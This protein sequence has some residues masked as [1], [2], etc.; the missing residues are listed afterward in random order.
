M[1]CRGRVADAFE[2]K[3]SGADVPEDQQNWLEEALFVANEIAPK[4]L[5]LL[6]KSFSDA[7]E[8]D[9]AEDMQHSLRSVVVLIARLANHPG[10][11]KGMDAIAK[12]LMSGKGFYKKNGTGA[13]KMDNDSDDEEEEEEEFEDDDEGEIRVPEGIALLKAV[14]KDDDFDFLHFPTPYMESGFDVAAHRGEGENQLTDEQ[15]A[16]VQTLIALQKRRAQR[17][18]AALDFTALTAPSMEYFEAYHFGAK[19]LVKEIKRENREEKRRRKANRR[20]GIERSDT[21]SSNSSANDDTTS[22]ETDSL[23]GDATGP[24]PTS[25]SELP[26]TLVGLYNITPIVDDPALGPFENPFM[27]EDPTY[28]QIDGAALRRKV[29]LNEQGDETEDDEEEDDDMQ[30]D[31]PVYRFIEINDENNMLFHDGFLS[32]KSL[33]NSSVYVRKL[34]NYIIRSGAAAIMFRRVLKCSILHPSVVNRLSGSPSLSA[35]AAPPETSKYHAQQYPLF[36]SSAAAFYNF[37]GA[38]KTLCRLLSYAHA[39]IQNQLHSHLVSIYRNVFVP[40]SVYVEGM[41]QDSFVKECDD[42]HKIVE[43]KLLTPAK[44]I[45]NLI[46]ASQS[47]TYNEGQLAALANASSY[48]RRVAPSP[49][50]LSLPGHGT[51]PFFHLFTSE[52][53]ST[54]SNLAFACPWNFAAS[55]APLMDCLDTPLRFLAPSAS[56]NGP[57]LLPPNFATRERTG[58]DISA[59]LQIIRAMASL[60]SRVLE[61]RLHGMNLLVDV[62]KESTSI[63]THDLGRKVLLAEYQ[64]KLERYQMD[65]S[66]YKQEA[67][68]R[69]QNQ[70]DSEARLLPLVPPRKPEHPLRVNASS[71]NT[72]FYAHQYSQQERK[73]NDLNAFNCLTYPLHCA[74]PLLLQQHAETLLKSFFG[75]RAHVA[76]TPKARDVLSFFSQQGLLTAAHLDYIWQSHLSK[77]ISIVHIVWEVLEAVT[78][79]MRLELVDHLFGL[80][81]RDIFHPEQSSLLLTSQLFGLLKII[82][83]VGIQMQE[84]VLQEELERLRVNYETSRGNIESEVQLTARQI[85]QGREDD[86]TDEQSAKRSA[87]LEEL[88]VRAQASL[89]ELEMHFDNAVASAS[90][91]P[92]KLYGLWTMLLV[93]TDGTAISSQI[94]VPLIQDIVSNFFRPL[95]EWIQC[96]ALRLPL[97]V[98]LLARIRRQSSVAQSISIFSAVLGTFIPHKTF[99]GYSPSQQR[100]FPGIPSLPHLQ[101]QQ[102]PNTNLLSVVPV[103]A[104]STINGTVEIATTQHLV[105]SLPIPFVST[106]LPVSFAVAWLQEHFGLQRIVVEAMSSYKAL[107]F[108]AEAGISFEDFNQSVLADSAQA[109]HQPI[110]SRYVVQ[111]IG[112]K[113]LEERRNSGLIPSPDAVSSTRFLAGSPF[114]YLEHIGIRHQ[115]MVEVAHVNSIKLEGVDLSSWWSLLTQ[116]T[117]TKRELKIVCEHLTQLLFNYTTNL[118]PVTDENMRLLFNRMERELDAHEVT[119]AGLDLVKAFVVFHSW[120]NSQYVPLQVSTSYPFGF[121]IDGDINTIP[122]LN[123]FWKIATHAKDLKAA[124]QAAKHIV[125]FYEYPKH[126]SSKPLFQTAFVNNAIQILQEDYDAITQKDVPKGDDQRTSPFL[127]I[128]R[129]LA[130][131]RKVL[132]SNRSAPTTRGAPIRLTLKMMVGPNPEIS[133]FYNDPVSLVRAKAA[134]HLSAA[135]ADIRLIISGKEL[136]SEVDHLPI[137]QLP[138]PLS[139]TPGSTIHVIKRVSM[140]SMQ[141]TAASAP[142]EAH[143]STIAS[144]L[145]SE[146]YF[147]LF[148][149]LLLLAS[150]SSEHNELAH[151]VWSLLMDLPHNRELMDGLKSIAPGPSPTATTDA[152]SNGESAMQ[153]EPTSP[154][155]GGAVAW[156]VLLD[157]SNVFKLFYSLQI[158][159]SLLRPREGSSD[160]TTWI[161]SF[162]SSGGV[163]HLLR[164]LLTAPL[165][166]P[167]QGFKRFPAASL[168]LDLL[169]IFV[170]ETTSNNRR[171]ISAT[172]LMPLLLDPFLLPSESSAGP[173]SVVALFVQRLMELGIGSA[174]EHVEENAGADANDSSDSTPTTP[175]EPSSQDSEDDINAV[176]RTTKAA[177]R[178][179]EGVASNAELLFGQLCPFLL[180]LASSPEHLSVILSAPMKPLWS[181]IMSVVFQSG[182]DD[183]KVRSSLFNT[184]STLI[185][186]ADDISG[187]QNSGVVFFGDIALSLAEQFLASSGSATSKSRSHA[188][189]FFSILVVVIGRMFSLDQS[190]VDSL[191]ASEEL[192]KWQL[193]EQHAHSSKL[194]ASSP[195]HAQVSKRLH[196]IVGHVAKLL[197]GYTPRERRGD[198]TVDGFLVGLLALSRA[199]LLLFPSWVYTHESILHGGDRPRLNDNPLLESETL[200]DSPATQGRFSLVC[201][202]GNLL[203]RIPTPASSAAAAASVT[204]SSSN[205]GAAAS[206]PPAC[207]TVEARTAAFALLLTITHPIII[208]AYAQLA[209]AKQN[210]PSAA[211]FHLNTLLDHFIIPRHTNRASIGNGINSWAYVPLGLEKVSCGYVGLRNLA[212]TCYM[213]SLMQQFFMIPQFRARIFSLPPYLPEGSEAAPAQN[214]GKSTLLD[215]RNVLFQLQNLFAHLQESQLKY[216]DPTS[217]TK[218]YKDPD[219]RVMNP[220]IQMDA[221]EF[222]AGL[223]DKIEMVV[224]GTSD[225]KAVRDSFGGSLWQQVEAKDCG[226]ISRREEEMLTIPVEVKGKAN[227]YQSLEAFVKADILD[228]DN[229]YQCSQCNQMVDARKYACL[230]RLPDNL[231]FSLKRFDFDFETLTRVKVHDHFEFPMSL[232]VEPYTA[233]G[234]RRKSNA[235]KAAEAAASGGAAPAAATEE[236]KFEPEDY[237]YTLSGIVIHR[238][239]ADSGHYYSYIKDRY[240]SPDRPRWYLF[241]DVSVESFD[242]HDIPALAFGGEDTHRRTLKAYSAYMLFYTKKKP[243]HPSS[244][245]RLETRQLSDSVPRPLFANTWLENSSFLLDQQIYDNYYL[246]FATSLVT[247]LVVG[248][249]HN[250]NEDASAVALTRLGFTLVT[251]TL[252]QMKVKNYYSVVMTNLNLLVRTNAAAAGALLSSLLT[253]QSASILNKVF[254][255]CPISDVKNGFSS[256]ISEALVAL[257]SS[258]TGDSK[259]ATLFVDLWVNKLL[260]SADIPLSKLPLINPWETIVA[261]VAS[262]ANVLAIALENPIARPLLAPILMPHVHSFLTLLAKKIT[263]P[264][265]EESKKKFKDWRKPLAPLVSL[266]SLLIASSDPKSVQ[267]PASYLDA[268]LGAGSPNTIVSLDDASAYASLPLNLLPLDVYPL[269]LEGQESESTERHI[270]SDRTWSYLTDD[271]L[272]ET[273]LDDPGLSASVS[274]PTVKL[275]EFLGASHPVWTR[276]L[277]IMCLGRMKDVGYERY[278]NLVAIVPVLVSQL[279]QARQLAFDAAHETRTRL[280]AALK[281]RFGSDANSDEKNAVDERWSWLLFPGGNSDATFKHF[282]SDYLSSSPAADASTGAGSSMEGVVESK[283]SPV[284]S[285]SSDQFL[286]PNFNASVVEELASI[287]NEKDG[288]TLLASESTGPIAAVACLAKAVLAHSALA[289]WLAH[290]AFPAL[291]ELKRGLK[292]ASYWSLRCALDCIENDFEVRRAV[293]TETGLSSPILDEY[294]TGFLIFEKCEKVRSIAE[295]IIQSST[296]GNDERRRIWTSTEDSAILDAALPTSIL[297]SLFSPVPVPVLP[298]RHLPAEI[299]PLWE[300]RDRVKAGVEIVLSTTGIQT[301]PGPSEYAEV[302]AAV[303]QDYKLINDE[304]IEEQARRKSGTASSAQDLVFVESLSYDSTRVS[305]QAIVEKQVSVMRRLWTTLVT[306]LK[307]VSKGT[308]ICLTEAT[309][310]QKERLAKYELFFKYRLVQLLRSMT[311]IL[312]RVP[313]ETKLALKTECYESCV[314]VLVMLWR[315]GVGE[316]YDHNRSALYAFVDV[317]SHDFSPLL[318]TLASQ[319][320]FLHMN[321][322]VDLDKSRAK[323]ICAFNDRTSSHFFRLILRAILLHDELEKAKTSAGDEQVVEAGRFTALSHAKSVLDIGIVQHAASAS[324]VPAVPIKANQ[325][326]ASLSEMPAWNWSM[327]WLYVRGGT[328]R[329]PTLAIVLEQLVR[330]VLKRVDAPKRENV[331]TLVVSLLDTLALTIASYPTQAGGGNTFG[332]GAHSLLLIAVLGSLAPDLYTY[333]HSENVDGRSTSPLSP[334]NPAKDAFNTYADGRYLA[335][336]LDASGFFMNPYKSLATSPFLPH[337]LPDVASPELPT[338]SPALS[339]LQIMPQG[340]SVTDWALK[341]PVQQISPLITL[342]LP[343]GSLN[344]EGSNGNLLKESVTSWMQDTWVLIEHRLVGSALAFLAPSA[345]A[346]ASLPVVLSSAPAPGTLPLLSFV[347]SSLLS[348]PSATPN[349]SQRAALDMLQVLRLSL[350]WVVPLACSKR[351][352]LSFPVTSGSHRPLSPLQ[353]IMY[354]LFCEDLVL[355]AAAEESANWIAT[356]QLKDAQAVVLTLIHA[357]LLNPT[358]AQILKPSTSSTENGAAASNTSNSNAQATTSMRESLLSLAIDICESIVCLSPNVAMTALA[359][360]KDSPSVDSLFSLAPFFISASQ[361]LASR[362]GVDGESGE[363]SPALRKSIDLLINFV[364]SSLKTGVTPVA[365]VHLACNIVYEMTA[366]SDTLSEFAKNAATAADLKALA[367]TDETVSSSLAG[368]L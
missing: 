139:V 87:D 22:S 273:L 354:K 245:V 178:K 118:F 13:Q 202:I 317:M 344:E 195:T 298:R 129:C 142:A 167:E 256:L 247:R 155:H 5:D 199:C 218:V 169:S 68:L 346:T 320:K 46:E 353:A 162:Q 325:V 60:D 149:N 315:E 294:L 321:I 197:V 351:T 253:P 262:S 70:G 150:S 268:S 349:P 266:I 188:G 24:S 368:I 342:V 312:M 91:Q 271:S 7:Q 304:M 261:S 77:H 94:T 104:P 265:D 323:P 78:P 41:R 163:R 128:S 8:D 28:D 158:V 47:L 1:R 236:D 276:H 263:G 119:T 274:E 301:L 308:A 186:L 208:S 113:A 303:Y 347:L 101:D 296:V 160:S 127:S 172:A 85:Q 40:M 330:L 292:L 204:S 45:S 61:R 177:V 189:E 272:L 284:S 43:I 229:K 176:A 173:E 288:W 175:A 311:W 184:I 73:I 313:H 111:C 83:S 319:D 114:T 222:F 339:A 145:S 275:F 192:A 52:E 31:D 337:V 217:F 226:H 278:E 2:P 48:R 10:L 72:G 242:E 50:L 366:T 130:L 302:Q 124:E 55:Q 237:E 364:A 314:D 241:N 309:R 14:T 219:G 33:Q 198:A 79:T 16:E 35:F 235:A 240:S 58:E 165:A 23:S 287:V 171:V 82:T 105:G 246:E 216:Y 51:T 115:F 62:A 95:M 190:L 86:T 289:H 146:P 100:E 174:M 18:R 345:G 352:K 168:L 54:L 109:A 300:D 250:A 89:Q 74:L 269:R 38:F 96:L 6:F 356:Q 341:Y 11:T 267:L 324:V 56:P 282:A 39:S 213:N 99:A 36:T 334:N 362:V 67:T 121:A 333:E 295:R 215:S 355:S 211:L 248:E 134:Q 98:H 225:E 37:T 316:E 200:A 327:Q 161:L 212:A 224:K 151:Q 306:I 228:G 66:N 9:G 148:F 350:S 340:L 297:N 322:H 132:S 243:S 120:R 318:L 179:E 258:K 310:E 363:W 164:L 4:Y 239:T 17:Y 338:Q 156:E 90:A 53:L 112:S 293:Q 131:I 206:V 358:A 209:G 140:T 44:L 88:Q 203:F 110:P 328:E 181:Q 264:V 126:E 191:A 102:Q 157:P 30:E 205:N 12:V 21:P 138:H 141:T 244:Q 270:L 93:L 108:Q 357:L 92:R 187:Q 280:I 15:V 221:E 299:N 232:S 97:L 365:Q 117:L 26:A 210:E 361:A 305:I 283:S 170:S 252:M 238:G 42:L 367:Q 286:P 223:L 159:E 233:D 20:A 332:S 136:K 154:T 259:T 29:R 3:P 183:L 137:S 231:V 81:Q 125:A 147:S 290:K 34:A 331:V 249:E 359:S 285:A 194:I 230:G 182:C 220:V 166:Q 153:V 57:Q 348:H 335:N 279:R 254:V 122:G 360:I 32:K 326:L 180:A 19:D 336:G 80:I 69:Q 329:Y 255:Q 144:L 196:G 76:V 281:T 135:P 185:L 260:E 75:A 234:L 123:L 106:H 214:T 49:V 65:L 71:S 25:S 143:V 64:L 59:E 27:D 227:L 152:E 307:A 193:L 291:F 277:L 107:V 84:T 343:A 207:K 63:I 251:E 133:L 103:P 201:S 116:W 257:L